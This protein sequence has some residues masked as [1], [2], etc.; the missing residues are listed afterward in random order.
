MIEWEAWLN[1]VYSNKQFEATVVGLDASTL[2]AGA[3]LKRFD[4]TAH[5]NFI[6]YSNPDYDT[7]YANARAAET[8]EEATGYYKECERILAETA[9]NVY[10]QDLVE[11]VAIN[12][13]YA[14]YEFYP[15][16]VMDIAKL[17]IV[18]E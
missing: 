15:S 6:N 12:K 9:A 5:N 7:A 16:Y 13:K 17:Y 4:S 2:T 14:G 18:E 8:D 10:I 1:D 11:F 3:M